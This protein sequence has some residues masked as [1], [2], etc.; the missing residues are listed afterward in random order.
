[1]T[2]VGAVI[3]PSEALRLTYITGECSGYNWS[4]H[5]RNCGE[6]VG[7]AQQDACI[8]AETHTYIFS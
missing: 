6:G 7:D 8:A 2:T 3:E 1:M 4:H 5:A